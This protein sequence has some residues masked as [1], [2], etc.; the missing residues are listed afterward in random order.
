MKEI[1]A[2]LPEGIHRNRVD[3]EYPVS[4]SNIGVVVWKIK[5]KK[6]KR[7]KTTG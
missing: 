7:V 1:W 2:S 5:E 3:G 6:T 4:I